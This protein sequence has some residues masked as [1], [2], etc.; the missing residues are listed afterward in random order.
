MTKKTLFFFT[1]E[2]IYEQQKNK[3]EKEIIYATVNFK[4]ILK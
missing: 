3:L 4:T 1:D 2:F